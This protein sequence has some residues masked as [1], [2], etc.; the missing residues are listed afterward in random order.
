[1]FNILISRSINASASHLS[2][3]ITSLYSANTLDN[4]ISIKEI[5]KIDWLKIDVEGVEEHVLMGGQQAITKFKPNIIVECH[6]FMDAGISNRVKKIL[7][8][9][10]DYKIEEVKRDP[11]I[12]LVAKVKKD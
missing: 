3:S 6:N 11:C 1:M 9:F 12:I 8:S 5:K 10:A 4:V 7:L 2:Q